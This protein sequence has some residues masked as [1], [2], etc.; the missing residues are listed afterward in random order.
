MQQNKPPFIQ[1]VMGVHTYELPYPHYFFSM[2]FILFILLFIPCSFIVSLSGCSQSDQHSS[3]V[4][5]DSAKLARNLDS[6]YTLREDDPAKSRK[7][8]RQIIAQAGT[9]QTRLL[10]ADAYCQY[11][12]LAE[13]TGNTD[14]AIYFYRSA[15][16]ID[17]E[18]KHLHGMARD[19]YMLSVILKNRGSYDSALHYTNEAARI[20]GTMPDKKEQMVQA[21]VGAANIHLKRSNYPKALSFYQQ[22]LDTAERINDS[23]MRF[24]A[25]QGMGQV[26]ERQNFN[27]RAIGVFEEALLI[28][29]TF[30]SKKYQAE[31]LNHLGGVYLKENLDTAALNAFNKAISIYSDIKLENKLAVVHINI[32]Q[33][34]EKEGKYSQ[35]DAYIRKSLEFN[36]KTNYAQGLSLCYFNI[37][38]L[39]IRQNKYD[40]AI[41]NLVKADS[42]AASIGDLS[43]LKEISDCL[44]EAHARKQNYSEAFRYATSGGAL[45]DTLESISQQ[46]S[47]LAIAYKEEQTKRILLEKE[48]DN[49]KARI[50]RINLIV[51]ALSVIIFLLLI[52]LF[53]LYRN[54]IV[55]KRNQQSKK[56]IEDLLS[57]QEQM[58]VQTML[59]TQ[60]KE[61][62]RIAQDLHDSL[63]VKL[64]TAK[65]YYNLMENMAGSLSAEE[66]EKLKKANSIL[67]EA[68]EEVRLVA[69]DLHKGELV[70]FGLV[71]AIEN[72][73][74]NINGLNK[75]QVEFH[76]NG[77]NSRLDGATEFNIYQI[78]RELMANILRHANASEVTIQLQRQNGNI[79]L[80]VEDNGNGFDTTKVQSRSGL[81]LTSL[82]NRATQINAT[83]HIDSQPGHGTSVSIDIPVH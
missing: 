27:I 34:Y 26:Y 13:N 9:P 19:R 10:K 75:L 73:C 37:G 69:A 49:Q 55:E 18:A 17:D 61:R 77:L 42:V 76:A 78:V 41:M 54:R 2:R 53:A 25:L 35:A 57:N 47:E 1:S 23:L 79:N 70:T 28:A 60:E 44:S 30:E 11:A 82:R 29:N 15:K 21:L 16:T 6:A 33:Y 48:R 39:L 64:S 59:E 45:R 24:K 51:L 56:Q 72:L 31:I 83:F 62:Q 7:I 65:L 74:N 12:R 36:Q 71:R 20:W 14:S 66:L 5:A 22:V 8:L 68:C 3:S 32:S 46:A 63:G 80:M 67:D 4:S 52:L 50:E 58:A 43:M 40:E 81:G 38:R